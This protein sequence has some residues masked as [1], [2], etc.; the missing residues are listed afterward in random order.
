M[1]ISHRVRAGILSVASVFLVTGCGG[2]GTSAYHVGGTV[3]GLPLGATVTLQDNGGD[4]L[5]VSASGSFG[6]AT[7]L[8]SGSAYAVTVKTQ[9][10]GGNCTVAGGSGT[11]AAADVTGIAVNCV[12][13]ALNSSTTSSTAFAVLATN[14][15][16]IA[17][18]P[19]T[20]TVVPL[21]IDGS[22]AV[23]G[24]KVAA[25][26]A[27]RQSVPSVSLSFTPD[28]CT[29]D[30][31]ALVVSCISY[32]ST[33]LAFLDVSRFAASLNTADITATEFESGAPNTLTSFSG[34]SCV[35]CGIVALTGRGQIV[36]AAHG[37]YR[38]Y[39][40]PASGAASP[41]V[42]AASDEVPITENFAA[43]PTRQW[44]AAS[45]YFPQGGNRKLRLIDLA[46]KKV[47]VWTAN[48]DTCA[49]GDDPACTSDFQSE[50][51]DSETFDLATGML[52]LRSESGSSQLLLDMSQ[53]SFDD[54]ALTF[55]APH[56][57]VDFENPY[58][59]EMSGA[60]ASPTHSW[61]FSVAEF[62]SAYIGVDA[63]PTAGG[64]GGTFPA[65]THQRVFVDLNTPA[66]IAPC[67]GTLQSGGDPHSEGYTTSLAGNEVGLFIDD[68]RSCIVKVDLKALYE[69]PRDTT[70]PTKVD[71]SYDL[72]A[73]GVLTYIKAD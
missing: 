27:G 36:V 23:H 2:D 4:D 15:A 49:P 30:S 70:D 25:L 43:D 67:T 35:F 11:V 6:F 59:A 31:S 71:A 9:P 13:T 62:S 46:K 34:G 69:A 48:T 58:F 44:I 65:Y 24:A 14:S 17:F 33:K 1:S 66:S 41:L 37:G 50:E 56:R 73:H 20:N 57:H 60:L 12:A 7:A 32:N 53:A 40:Y 19:G 54:A 5:T 21:T 18:L 3:N 28:S 39:A 16:R 55:T 51:I 64:S 26:N 22:T 8:A 52:V 10:A 45:E 29:V 47:Y 38:V 61:L 68:A 42:P 72:V 63:L